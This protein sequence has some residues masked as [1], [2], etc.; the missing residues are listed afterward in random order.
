[1]HGSDAQ[2]AMLDGNTFEH[3]AWAK[4]GVETPINQHNGGCIRGL[5]PPSTSISSLR[6]ST[7]HS[8]LATRHYSRVLL[9]KN[10]G[11]ENVLPTHAGNNSY[12]RWG[13]RPTPCAIQFE[14]SSRHCALLSIL[15]GSLVRPT[16]SNRTLSLFFPTIMPTRPSVPTATSGGLTRRRTSIAW[17]ARACA[18]IA[19]WCPTPFAGPAGPPC[20]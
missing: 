13:G 4:S 6:D 14:L 20:S 11:I 1:M 19:A 5:K 9:R 8:P 16:P 2:S 3:H 17:D 18:S 7:R 15:P 12:R 10:R